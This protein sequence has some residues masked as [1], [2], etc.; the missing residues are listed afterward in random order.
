MRKSEES[1]AVF[2]V[3]NRHSN[4]VASLYCAH[5][6][7]LITQMLQ[8]INRKRPFTSCIAAKHQNTAHLC[9]QTSEKNQWTFLWCTR[10]SILT[11]T[12]IF[13][14]WFLR[15][16]S[17]FCIIQNSLVER[18]LFKELSHL[19]HTLLHIFYGVVS[20]IQYVFML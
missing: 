19:F 12:I 17:R 18:E 9:L 6:N 20:C 5:V 3:I 11:P 15:K 2:K 7:Q 8:C 1:E 16:D 10:A 4:S 14:A 13:L